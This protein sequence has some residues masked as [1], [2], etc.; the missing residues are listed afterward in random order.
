MMQLKPYQDSR[1]PRRGAGIAQGFFYSS[2]WGSGMLLQLKAP[3]QSQA[4]ATGLQA[5]HT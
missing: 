1:R 5:T 4:G 2:G 3:V